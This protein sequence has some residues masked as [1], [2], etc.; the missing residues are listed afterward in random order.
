MSAGTGPTK[1]AATL[2]DVAR[3]AGVS[4]ATASRVLNGSTRH[5]AESYRERVEVAAQELGYTPNVSAQATARG[6][7]K[8]AALLVADIA[9]P[10]FGRLASGVTRGADELGLD[11][12]IYVT[13]RD[14]RRE[15]QL[16]HSLRGLR[17]RGIILAASR[18]SGHE[19]L[20]L[21]REL[22]AI[23]YLGGRVVTLGAGLEGFRSIG[24]GNFSAA[25]SLALA[26]A[27]RGYRDAVV[28]AAHE[29]VRTS[30]ERL[31]GFAQGF[32][33]AGGRIAAIVRG[34]FAREDGH[35]AGSQ[36]LAQGLQTGTL[37]FAV[38]DVLAMG[39]FAAVNDA[40]RQVGTDLAIA[41]FDDIE[42][43]RD[44]GITTVRMPLHDVGLRA[45]SALSEAEWKTDEGDGFSLEVVI[46][47]STPPVVG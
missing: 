35:R 6:T 11:V 44:Y 3:E 36:L 40:G 46:R 7:S 30:D 12:L 31:A 39:A 43:A 47:E 29:G 4:L 19:E 8:I 26:L 32:E 22:E 9:D 33:S 2:H 21:A 41:G 42:F 15:V 1:G 13:E 10:Y 24:V 28:V 14:P 37:I 23:E 34:G 18:A 25:R 17:P 16:V 5:V 38:T 45:I 20:G 27:E